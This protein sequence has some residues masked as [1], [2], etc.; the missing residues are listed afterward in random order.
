MNILI[1]TTTFHPSIGGIEKQ[2]QA[3][4]YEFLRKGH[5]VKMINIQSLA[6]KFT[7]GELK[8]KN[9]DIY[10][11]PGFLKTLQ[12]FLW[13]TTMY[14]PNFSLRASWFLFMSPFKKLIISHNDFYLS[15]KKSIKIRIKRFLIKFASQNI[16]VS[17]AVAN[18]INTKSTIIYNCYDNEIFKIYKDEE[19]VY[20]FVFLGRLVSQKGCDLL[21]K[22]CKNL[23]GPFFLNIIGDG[24]ERFKL[25]KMVQDFDLEQNIKFRGILEGEYLARVLNRH[26]IMIIPSIGEE[27]FGVVALEGMA[28]GCRIIAAD[29]GG[30]SE[31]INGFGKTFRIG[32]QKELEYLLE[33]YMKE[34]KQACNDIINADLNNYLTAHQKET[35][36]ARY[37]FLFK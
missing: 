33:D 29:A 10:F 6:I 27:G 36:A 18:Y 11:R 20:D 13:C 26:K 23:K 3:L 21:I 9:A 16:S 37:L 5:K 34:S 14:M 17:N 35:I 7:S 15:N 22:A 25:E 19:R 1:F 8:E 12:L 28:C 2:T 30:L 31:A 32:D 24:P 4:V